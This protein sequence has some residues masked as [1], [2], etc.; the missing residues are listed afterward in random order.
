MSLPTYEQAVA[1]PDIIELVAPYLE[2]RE[3]ATASRVSKTWEKACT[4]LLWGD[5]LW[6]VAKKE[7][8]FGMCNI[9]QQIEIR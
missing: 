7:N 2:S 9:R 8:P 1:K 6:S 3:L 4:P 5:P